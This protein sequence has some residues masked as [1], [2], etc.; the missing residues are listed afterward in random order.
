MSRLPLALTV[1]A[2]SLW[3]AS[4]A[5]AECSVRHGF[6]EVLK[7]SPIAVVGK[8]L[9]VNPGRVDLEI[10]WVVKGPAMMG[11]ITVWDPQVSGSVVRSVNA[12]LHRLKVGVEIVLAGFTVA[13][14]PRDHLVNVSFDIAAQPNDLA[15]LA[16]HQS[17]R[18]LDSTEALRAFVGKKIP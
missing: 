1:V 18:V 9:T 6:E 14:F 5:R 17:Y 12:E 13:Q 8:V 2:L 11:R 15:V 4:F 10:D 3:P 16:C 7:D